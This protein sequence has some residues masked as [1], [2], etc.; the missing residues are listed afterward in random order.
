MNFFKVDKKI[1]DDL[2]DPLYITIIF[3]NMNLR[4]KIMISMTLLCCGLFFIQNSFSLTIPVEAD[5][6][7][8]SNLTIT[9]SYGKS[10]VLYTNAKSDS[11]IR[12]D[13]SNF[14]D[15]INSSNVGNV[16]LLIQINKVFK[17]G[18]ISIHEITSD[19]T[20]YP[21]SKV[22]SPS[23][24]VE[25]LAD[26]QVGLNDS[27]RFI[28]V[29]LTGL[30]RKWLETNNSD[31]GIAL[32]SDGEA[33][34]TIPSKE[35]AKFGT[36]AYLE[37]DIT[38]LTSNQNLVPGVDATKL[39]DGSVENAE[40]HFL[41]GVMS[42]IQNQLGSLNAGIQAAENKI[43]ALDSSL[44]D[45]VS[46][47]GDSMSG[48]LQLPDNGLQIGES[49]LTFVN[50]NLGLGTPSPLSKLQVMGDITFGIDGLSKIPA[51][52]ESIS[53]VRGAIAVTDSGSLIKQSG[54][55][56]RFSPSGTADID[57]TFD[58]PFSDLPTIQLTQE[59][60]PITNNATSLRI[61]NLTNSGF[62]VTSG[63]YIVNTAVHFTAAGNP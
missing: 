48:L 32:K 12:F 37:I 34:A 35:G 3:A 21:A 28:E 20:E 46:R 17:S 43:S 23:I 9:N 39:G 13:V 26:I 30:V 61:K 19:W 25:A 27:H 60:K 4:K 50:G 8:G 16:R 36:A 18:S 6:F 63:R 44:S 58:K 15:V 33:S 56:F 45:K 40:F 55:G 5:S 1:L 51:T 47:S 29:D 41:D 54:V 57:V 49:M 24:D 31:F 38:Q 11:F 42:P 62:T 52:I 7:S 14:K 10:G 22:T 53:F 59:L 2:L